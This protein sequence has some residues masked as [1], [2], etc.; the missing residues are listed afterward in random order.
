ME[1][2]GVGNRGVEI[3]QEAARALARVG[4]APAARSMAR[5]ASAARAGVSPSSITSATLNW[6]GR[7][8]CSGRS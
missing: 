4:I 7:T 3:E 8:A 2:F 5:R 1:L 6:F